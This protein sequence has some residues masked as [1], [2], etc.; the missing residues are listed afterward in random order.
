MCAGGL[1]GVLNGSPIQ[2][3]QSRRPRRPRSPPRS[4]S[5]MAQA[6]A[7]LLLGERAR[8]VHRLATALLALHEVLGVVRGGAHGATRGLGVLSDLPLDLADGLAAVRL[9][10]DLVT[11]RELISHGETL[12]AVDGRPVDGSV[13]F[14]V[15]VP[16]RLALVAG[17]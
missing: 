4:D 10:G 3:W 2:R 8:L 5:G 12:R 17:L 15:P 13:A 1:D 16:V 7:V 9:P 11:L 6:Q 14:A